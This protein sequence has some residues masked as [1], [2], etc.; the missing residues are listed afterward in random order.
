MQMNIFKG[1]INP[2]GEMISNAMFCFITDNTVET[3]QLE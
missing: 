3:I 2:K 1:R